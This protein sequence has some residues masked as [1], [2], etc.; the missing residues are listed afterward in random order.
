[1]RLTNKHRKA[2]RLVA[3]GAMSMKDICAECGVSKQSLVVWKRKPEFQKLINSY[4]E[5]LLDND[6]RERTL[7]ET[8]YTTL[9]NIMKNGVNEGAKVNAA[10]YVVEKFRKAFPKNSD[11]EID[12]SD[13]AQILKLVESKKK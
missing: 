3:Q 7:L 5:P 13:M 10:K 8:A 9:D 6:A 4:Y 1:M 12:H 2:A 11:T